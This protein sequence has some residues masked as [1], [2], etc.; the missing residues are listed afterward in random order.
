MAFPYKNPLSSNQL[1]ASNSVARTS[2]FGTNFSV[3]Q[4]GGYMEV[5]SLSDLNWSTFGASGVIQNSGNTIPIQF[6][7]GGVANTLTLNS[8]NISSG[9]RRLGMQVYVYETDTVYH[10]FQ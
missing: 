3:L 1:S 10:S 9:R 6:T 4:T 2:T 5:Y 8:D 7:V